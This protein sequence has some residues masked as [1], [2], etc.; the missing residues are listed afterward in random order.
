MRGRYA[1]QTHLEM[2]GIVEKEQMPQKSLLVSKASWD[3]IGLFLRNPA[4]QRDQRLGLAIS[5]ALSQLGSET[6]SARGCHNLE[7][8]PKERSS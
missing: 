8:F 3:Q 2:E 6:F 7:D 1:F 4:T 5:G